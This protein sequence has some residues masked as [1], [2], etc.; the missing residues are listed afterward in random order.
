MSAQERD[1]S[2]KLV[3]WLDG[4][5]PIDEAAYL[6]QHLGAGVACRSEVEA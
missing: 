2:E 3:A 6:E 1:C 4:E 5:L